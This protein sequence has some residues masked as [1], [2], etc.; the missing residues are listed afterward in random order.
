MAWRDDDPITRVYKAALDGDPLSLLAI[1]SLPDRAVAAV[2]K[3]KKRKLATA[4]PPSRWYEWSWMLRSGPTTISSTSARTT[5]PY[6]TLASRPR[7][8]LPTTTAPG[9]IQAVG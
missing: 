3:G 5:A 9:A 6:Q 7:I 4:R 2:T 1:E 8:I